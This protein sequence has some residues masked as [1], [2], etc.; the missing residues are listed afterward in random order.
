MGDKFKEGVSVQ[1]LENFARKY[2]TEVFLILALIIAAISSILDFF[3][4]PSWSIGVV[5]LGA[6]ISI[7][8]PE[9]V[10]SVQKKLFK[11]LSRPEKTTQYIVGGVRLVLAIFLPF[12]LFAEVGLLAGI[13]FHNIPKHLLHKKEEKGTEETPPSEEEE[14]L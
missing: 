6:I 1:E 10:I 11:F 2:T 7:A 9:K 14:H 5:A 3:T 4:G 8:F 13:A 12:I